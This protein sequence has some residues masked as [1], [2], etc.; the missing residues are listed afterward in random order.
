M[1]LSVNLVGRGRYWK[2]GEEIPDEEVPATIRR[3]AVTVSGDDEVSNPP[4]CDAVEP[5]PPAKRHVKAER[6]R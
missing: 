4:A 2:A 3:Y 6:R 1:K 5:A